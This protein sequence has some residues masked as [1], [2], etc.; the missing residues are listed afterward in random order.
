MGRGRW[1]GDC[2]WEEGQGALPTEMVGPW[3]QQRWD[4]VKGEAEQMWW[5]A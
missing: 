4:G 5:E 1:S 3:N 2:I